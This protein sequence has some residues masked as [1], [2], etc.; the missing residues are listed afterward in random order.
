MGGATAREITGRASAN[1]ASIPYHFGS[2]DVLVAEALVDEAR[3]LVAPVFEILAEEAPGPERASRMVVTL[4]SLF[5]R[6]RER[7]PVYLSALA[8]APH[9]PEVR[10]ALAEIWSDLSARLADDIAAQRDIGALPAWVDPPAM[11]AVIV[12]VV[13]GVVVG[14]ALDPDRF[15][16]APVAAQFLALLL[17]AAGSERARS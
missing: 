15:D 9:S 13:N 6:S 11:A 17:G 7:V 10:A 1:L 4:G 3:E 2:K 16:P 12:A 5:E 8:A 14:A